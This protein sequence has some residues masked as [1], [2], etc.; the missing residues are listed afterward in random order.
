MIIKNP[1]MEA[2]RYIKETRNDIDAMEKIAKEYVTGKSSA[3]V[4]DA[5]DKSSDSLTVLILVEVKRQHARASE[6]L[7]GARPWTD[8]ARARWKKLCDKVF[9][10]LVVLE[11]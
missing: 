6:F 9:D 11:D 8:E 4:L 1:D 7:F 5:L 2:V 3:E 10:Y